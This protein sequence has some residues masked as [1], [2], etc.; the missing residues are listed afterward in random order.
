MGHMTR[1][2]EYIENGNG[3]EVCPECGH[4]WTEAGPGHEHDCR[5]YI[6]E[7]DVDEVEAEDE[8]LLRQLQLSLFRPAA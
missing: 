7:D 1:V 5:Y 8:A 6:L 3:A 2:S 4:A